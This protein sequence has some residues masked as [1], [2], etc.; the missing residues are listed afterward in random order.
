MTGGEHTIPSALPWPR[1]VALGAVVGLGLPLAVWAGWGLALLTVFI[2]AAIAVTLVRGEPTDFFSPPLLF[3]VLWVLC[4]VIGAQIVSVEQSAWNTTVWVC[5]IG[6]PIAF[7][8]GDLVGRI[9]TGTAGTRLPPFP[10]R[11]APWP[12]TPVIVGSSLWLLAAAAMSAYEF[13][14]LSGGIPLLSESWERLRMIGGE[15]YVGRVIH[16]VAYSGP[17]LAIALQVAI[18]TQPR[19]LARRTLPLWLLWAMA[20]ILSALWGSRHTL[21]IP[22]AAGVVSLHVLRWRLGLGRL[23][24]AALVGLTFLGGVQLLRQQSRWAE[25]EI[26]WTDVL[27]DIGY[28]GW[29]TVAAQIHQTVAMNFEI[30][31]RLTETFPDQVPHTMG[32]FTFHWLHSLLPGEQPTL[33]EWQNRHWNTGFYGSLTST[34]MGTLYADFGVGGVMMWTLLFAVLMR[35]L[36]DSLRRGPTG[37]KAVWFSYFTVQMIF[38]PYDNTLVKLAMVLA[39][40]ILW[41]GLLAMGAHRPL[42]L[43][44]AGSSG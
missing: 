8:L 34:H 3:T 28:G 9:F 38:M 33:A 39:I 29:P 43:T 15:G 20:L 12:L 2:A 5:V 7:L 32:R 27:E 16:A 1:A 40:L 37:V 31:R 44:R 26:P 21:F 18:L 25:E 22:A 36:Y 4:A 35:C 13:R 42:E 11:V 6:V 41:L 10:R 17:L 14:Y 19:L 24:L 30:F 23:A